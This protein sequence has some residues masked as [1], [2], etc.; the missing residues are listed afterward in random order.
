MKRLV[1]AIAI[2][3]CFASCKNN[4]DSNLKMNKVM[5][6]DTTAIY[7][8]SSSS[9]TGA[10]L[11]KGE[12]PSHVYVNHKT[13][14]DKTES[15]TSANRFTETSTTSTSA[16][17][18]KKK[19]WS[20]RAKDAVIGGAAGAVGIGEHRTEFNWLFRSG[21]RRRQDGAVRRC[22]GGPDPGPP[23]S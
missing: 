20:N 16:T 5:L 19:G 2:S 15:S 22:G 12:R 3:A 14:A 6:T 8:S 23:L 1:L 7:N 17:T 4:D 9:E 11:Q 21:E 10:A 13:A 18:T